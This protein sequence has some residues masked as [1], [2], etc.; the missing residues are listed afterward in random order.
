MARTRVN[1]PASPFGK[2]PKQLGCSD[3][4]ASEPGLTDAMNTVPVDYVFAIQ[5]HTAPRCC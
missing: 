3:I 1:R 2:A 4:Q 5:L